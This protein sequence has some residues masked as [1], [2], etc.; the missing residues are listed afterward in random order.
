[1]LANTTANCHT[2]NEVVVGAALGFGVLSTSLL[3]SH[4]S[5]KLF[6]TISN[7]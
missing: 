5:Q 3:I 7:K 4:L 1:M 2:L 6:N